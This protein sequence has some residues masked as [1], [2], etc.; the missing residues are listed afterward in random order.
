MYQG[1]LGVEVAAA[2][3]TITNLQMKS[4]QRNFFI[5]KYFM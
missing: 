2:I 5:K 3:T 4:N 1:N